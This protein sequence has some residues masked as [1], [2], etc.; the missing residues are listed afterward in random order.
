MRGRSAHVEI[1]N[2]RSILGPAGGRAQKE[3]LLERQLALKNISFRQ[4]KVP[5]EIERSQHLAMQNQILDVGRVL[6][7]GIDYRVANSSRLS[8][9]LPSFKL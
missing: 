9:Q 1:A 5:F 3:K 6:C 7:D 8:S 4:T 2:R